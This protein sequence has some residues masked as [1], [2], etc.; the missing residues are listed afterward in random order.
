M[1]HEDRF[2]CVHFCVRMCMRACVCLSPESFQ[3]S[4]IC[5]EVPVF[6]SFSNIK[7]AFAPDYRLRL[8][9]DLVVCFLD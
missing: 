6:C 8:T 9:P 2:V 1:A 5:C 7:I 3:L 4:S